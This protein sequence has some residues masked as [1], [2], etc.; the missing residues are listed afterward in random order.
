MMMADKCQDC[1]KTDCSLFDAAPPA[2]SC[3]GVSHTD[4]PDGSG[5]NNKTNAEALPAAAPA[6]LGAGTSC[7]TVLPVAQ[8]FN[9]SEYLRASWYVQQQQV[10]GYQP[11]ENLYCVVQTLNVEGAKVPFY[12]GVVTTV[13]NFATAGKVNGPPQN[14]ANETKL[15]ARQPNDRVRAAI[16]NAPC[17]LPNLLAGDYWVV[18]IG[19]SPASYEW[20]IISAGQPTVQ[21]KDGCTTK[22]TGTNGAGLWL[23]TRDAMPSKDVVP[24]MRQQLVTMGYTLDQLIDV[25]QQGCTYQGAL[26]KK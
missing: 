8:G 5:F 10:T 17:F 25:P 1:N 15:C 9:T 26:I 3:Y 2:K 16:I 20:A 13:Y 18:A 7:K 14:T 4:A 21:Y 6:L 12:S 22:T 23:F 11:K 19:P 24:M